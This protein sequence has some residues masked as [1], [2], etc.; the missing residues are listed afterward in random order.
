VVFSFVPVIIGVKRAV[1]P[2][3]DRLARMVV[4]MIL[5]MEVNRMKTEGQSPSIFIMLVMKMNEWVNLRKI[6]QYEGE[7]E[8][9]NS[10]D[11]RKVLF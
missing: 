10:T 11:Q 2:S 5:G 1:L 8:D 4:G 3:G 7:Q 9:R 6:K